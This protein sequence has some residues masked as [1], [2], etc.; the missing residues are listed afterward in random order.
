MSRVSHDPNLDA[1]IGANWKW[2][3][4][5]SISLKVKWTN[6]AQPV[7]TLAIEM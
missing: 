2:K 5:G 7:T 4:I 1:Q 3:I 6:Y